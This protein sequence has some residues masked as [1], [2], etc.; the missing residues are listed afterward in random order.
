MFYQVVCLDTRDY[1]NRYESFSED[2]EEDLLKY[3]KT[4]IQESINHRIQINRYEGRLP[5]QKDKR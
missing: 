1:I 5:Q 4:Q 2:E 3:I